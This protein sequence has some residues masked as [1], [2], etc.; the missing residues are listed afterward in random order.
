MDLTIQRY[1]IK[2]LQ[3]TV[4]QNLY[5]Q[6]PI[7]TSITDVLDSTISKMEIQNCSFVIKRA[8]MFTFK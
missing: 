6:H 8:F 4:S 2:I 5:N 3:K 7:L 1:I